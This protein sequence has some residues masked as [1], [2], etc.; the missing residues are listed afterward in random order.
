M[1][2]IK[3]KFP[4]VNFLQFFT[5]KTQDS[6]LPDSDPDLGLDPDPDT[7]SDLDPDPQLEKILDPDPHYINAD[8]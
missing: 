4:T 1:K 6:E 7:H 3:K 2:K 5:I 8:P